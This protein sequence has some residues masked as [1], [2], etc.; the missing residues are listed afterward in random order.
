MGV[1]LV[2]DRGEREIGCRVTAGTIG[3]RHQ[4]KRV[5]RVGTWSSKVALDQR[6]EIAKNRVVNSQLPLEIITHLAL[7]LVDLSKIEH[8]MN[9]GG[10]AL[11]AVGAVASHS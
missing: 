2:A 10:P 8:P 1:L 3:V 5:H 11:V 6:F 4:L 9:D 7:H